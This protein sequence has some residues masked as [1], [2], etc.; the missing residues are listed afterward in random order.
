M[1]KFEDMIQETMGTLEQEGLTSTTSKTPVKDDGVKDTGDIA[2]TNR[3]AGDVNHP[4]HN[5]AKQKKKEQ[6][7]K[8]RRSLVDM[9]RE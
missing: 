8:D 7:E 9:D 6:E 5:K 2:D 4:L 1:G 3:M